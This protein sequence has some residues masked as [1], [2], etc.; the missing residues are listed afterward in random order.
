MVATHNNVATKDEAAAAGSNSLQ[1]TLVKAGVLMVYHMILEYL[2]CNTAQFKFISFLVLTPFAKAIHFNKL[3]ERKDQIQWLY[4]LVNDG[5]FAF[6]FLRLF[7][8]YLQKGYFFLFPA[9]NAAV[10]IILEMIQHRVMDRDEPY[11]I[12]STGKIQDNLLSIVV[13]STFHY[14]SLHLDFDNDG[15]EKAQAFLVFFFLL[16]MLDG[17]FGLSHYATHVVPALWKR[18]GIHH[19]YKKERLNAFANFYSDFWDSCIMNSSIFM[20]GATLCMVFGRYHVSYMD[21]IYSAGSTHLRYTN[22]QMNLIYFFE[23]DLIDMF[24]GKHRIGNFHAQHHQDSS[25]NFCA[26]GIVSDDLIK[27]MVHPFRRPC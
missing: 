23:W 3:R 21:I 19:Q 22:K 5:I 12:L 20:T 1:Y 24:L 16:V 2:G 8:P 18:H 4:S 27:A 25:V 17:S 13:S 26:Y 15:M 14:M 7:I 11:D 9:L 6:I 10:F